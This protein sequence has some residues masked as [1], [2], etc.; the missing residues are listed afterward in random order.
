MQC[1]SNGRIER[2]GA[3]SRPVRRCWML[4]MPSYSLMRRPDIRFLVPPSFY[5]AVAAAP[6]GDKKIPSCRAQSTNNVRICFIGQRER[7]AS[8]CQ[9][10][11]S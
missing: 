8:T 3:S 5:A 10:I 11:T 6:S 9:C 2:I 1:S 4:I 7:N